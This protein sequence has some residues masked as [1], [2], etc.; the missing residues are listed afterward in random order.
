MVFGNGK[1]SFKKAGFPDAGSLS[2]YSS[3]DAPVDLA[4]DVKKLGAGRSRDT[5]IVDKAVIVKVE[6][7]V[8]PGANSAESIAYGGRDDWR[9]N[10]HE[11]GT[12]LRDSA[13]SFSPDIMKPG[14]CY[15]YITNTWNM[16]TPVC[17]L[18]LERLAHPDLQDIIEESA[19]DQNV[20]KLNELLQGGVSAIIEAARAGFCV[21]DMRLD[22]VGQTVG[23]KVVICDLGG[24]KPATCRHVKHSMVMFMES[25]QQAIAKHGGALEFNVHDGW[26]SESVPDD[27]KVQYFKGLTCSF[28]STV[29]S[30]ALWNSSPMPV[31]PS[32]SATLSSTSSS[33][34]AWSSSPT[35]TSPST[36]WS[37]SPMPS[38]PS[39]SWTAQQVFVKPPPPPP[40]QWEV[41]FYTDTVTGVKKPF[42]YDVVNK[43]S[44]WE[45]PA[46]CETPTPVQCTS[47]L[48]CTKSKEDAPM[49][50][51][52]PK[53]D[54]WCMVCSKYADDAHL[55]SEKHLKYAKWWEQ[56][57]QEKKAEWAAFTEAKW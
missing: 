35:Q 12:I 32:P 1:T 17:A 44:T 55:T 7:Q 50:A 48:C 23:G 24:S 18:F 27:A 21:G 6:V 28:P 16:E 34:W 56:Q 53:G 9:T 57:S 51:K 11:Y 4:F 42:Y 33:S 45:M 25:F 54:V 49:L 19:V 14:L 26:A 5:Y 40:P 2:I 30:F 46:H 41:H 20:R 47:D 13:K 43:V 38:S 3:A 10:E 39:T 29:G 8:P 31:S 36:S 52:D 37:S 15:G 22:N